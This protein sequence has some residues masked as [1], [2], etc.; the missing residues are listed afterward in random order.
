MVRLEVVTIKNP[1]KKMEVSQLQPKKAKFS[2]KKH[3]PFVPIE[4]LREKCFE[5]LKI[6]EKRVHFTEKQIQKINK[7]ID[8]TRPQSKDFT[9]VVIQIERDIVTKY[10]L[11][12]AL[13]M[14]LDPDGGLAKYEPD[15]IRKI[16]MTVGEFTF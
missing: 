8:E 15:M 11:Y 14:W 10:K 12:D 4:K 6:P 5:N 13:A 16:A 2:S 3:Q 1:S 9:G 7:I